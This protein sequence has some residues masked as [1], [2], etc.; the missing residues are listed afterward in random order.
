MNKI[1]LAVILFAAT[2]PSVAQRVTRTYTDKSMSEVLIDLD[3]ASSRYKISFIYNELEDFTVTTSFVNLS[4]TDA[5]QKC[6]GFYPA[7]M[8]VRD[9]IIVVE[10]TQKAEHKLTGRIIDGHGIPVPYANI[11]LLAPKDSCFITGGVS[12]ENGDFVIPC[13]ASE[14][15]VRVTYVG[16]RTLTFLTKPRDVGTLQMKEDRTTLSGVT[17]TGNIPRI[18]LKGSALT[19]T[20]AGTILEKIGTAEDVVLRAPTVMKNGEAIEVI[21]KGVPVIYINGRKV[22]G[23]LELSQLQSD[24]IKS[25][26]VVQNPGARYDAT[27]NAVIVIRTKRPEG[28]GVGIEVGS[29]TRRSRGFVNNERLS[30]TYRKG[31]FEFFAM[32]FGAYNKYKCWSDYIQT[33]HSENI[34]KSDHTEKSIVRNDYFEGKIGFNYQPGENHSLGAYYH[35]SSDKLHDRYEHN[36]ELS[37]D[38]VPYDKLSCTLVSREHWRPM[39]NINVYYNGAFGK[40]GI[41]FNSDYVHR[42]I[43]NTKGN[44]ENS[45]EYADREVNTR[46]LSKT[47]MIAEKLLLTYPLWKGQ[48]TVGEEFTTTRRI[49]RFS[50]EEGYIESS[51]NETRECNLAPFMELQQHLEKVNLGIGL[52]YEHTINEFYVANSLQNEVSMTYDKLFPSASLSWSFNMPSLFNKQPVSDVKPLS[53]IQMQLSY[54]TRTRRPTYDQLKSN[55]HYENRFNLQIGNPLLKPTYV[56]NLSFMAM[57]RWLF[58]SVNYTYNKDEIFFTTTFYNDD[59]TV[60]LVTFINYPH[61]EN[62][63]VTLGLNKTFEMKNLLGGTTW[64]PQWNFTIMKQWFTCD[65]KNGQMSFNKPIFMTR[66][67][68]VLSFSHD[69]MCS[70]DYTILSA[71]QQMNANFRTPKSMFNMSVSKDFF[72]KKIN[73]KLA[74]NDLFDRWINRFT[75]YSNHMEFRKVENDDQSYIC[76]S[77]RYRL[78][79][80]HSKYKGAGAGNDEKN[81]L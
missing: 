24:Q 36:D 8:T 73:A 32:G 25:V 26:E 76:L 56:H 81:R 34:W 18:E 63:S 19:M 62:L 51:E 59:P 74:V 71:G 77:L 45:Q 23:L 21:G 49:N 67:N 68:N 47:D 48:I 35:G 46:S 37:V 41:D 52:R 30:L 27:V 39:H 55:V 69:W 20:V 31:G 54:A 13:D 40:L 9:S 12:N 61:R 33:T 15:I 10:C 4:I 43:A 78:N 65:F 14:V 6:I 28:E 60:N 42:H 79:M 64:M 2:V 75:L 22:D 16:Y 5:L 38:G 50:N 44:D 66:L 53:P 17:V 70:I 7:S 29:Y 58:M 57:W 1:F 3:R 72:K 11:S 80:S